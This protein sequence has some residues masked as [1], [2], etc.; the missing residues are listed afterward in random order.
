MFRNYDP[1]LRPLEKAVE[2]V[3]ALN[4]AKLDKVISNSNQ[5]VS[6]FVEKITCI[7]GFDVLYNAIILVYSGFRFLQG[8]L[9]EQ[10]RGI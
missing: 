9:L 1:T 4:A 5:I 3:R 10:W 8:H 2:Y 6:F 7:S